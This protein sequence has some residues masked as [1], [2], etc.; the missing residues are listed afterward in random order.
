MAEAAGRLDAVV[1]NAGQMFV[2]ITEAFTPEQFQAQLDVNLVGPFRVSRAALPHMRRQRSGLLLHVSTVAA[3]FAGP[4]FALYHASKHGLEA[5][6][7]SLR[8]ELAP[9]GIDSCLI[10]PGPF[11][12]NLF[13]SSP[14]PEDAE[15]EAENEAL[16]PL[17][18]QVLA[19]F[20][21]MFEDPDLPTD[22][23]FV[24]EAIVDLIERPAGERPLRTIVGLDLG[25]VGRYNEATAPFAAE[26]LGAFGIGHLESVRSATN[27]APNL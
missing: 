16:H 15:R 3:R 5:L 7:E 1:N 22:P 24:V 20:G 9:Y 2:G 26:V 27:A 12:T 18:E 13:P 6:A 17:M 10:E 23:A 25:V 21:P 14:R 4:F 11:S 8:Y 19:G